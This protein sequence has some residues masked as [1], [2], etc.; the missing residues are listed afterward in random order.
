MITTSKNTHSPQAI[1]MQWIRH[2]T[3]RAAA[4]PVVEALESR[5]ML[6]APSNV[7]AF[8]TS[9]T[10]VTL[11]WTDNA[12][13]ETHF[14]VDRSVDGVN[15]KRI[16]SVPANS[17][18]FPDTGLQPGN[19]YHYR[20]KAIT[21]TV[22]SGW[23]TVSGS[24]LTTGTKVAPGAPAG[25]TA[26][27]PAPTLMT[28][29]WFDTADNE[30]HHLLERSLDGTN[31]KRIASMG[32]NVTE[33]LDSGL[34]PGV[35][36]HYRLRSVNGVAGSKWVR[37]SGTTVTEPLPAAPSDFVAVAGGMHQMTLTWVDNASNETHFL[38]DRSTDGVNFTR[39]ASLA[40]NSNTFTDTDLSSGTTYHYSLRA[41]HETGGS[42][43]VRTS[44]DTETPP[45]PPPQPD[46]LFTE[47]FSTGSDNFL[48]ISGT[49][50]V[51]GG[52]YQ[53]TS[54]SN[55]ATTH[56]NN[57]A[58]HTTT[59]EGDF[60]LAVDG[61]VPSS[62]GWADFAVIF[63]YQ[64]ANNY[65]FFSSNQSNDSLTSGIFKVVN[66][67]V[68]ELAEAAVISTDTT[69]RVRVVRSGSSISVYRDGTLVAMVEDETF[70]SGRIGFGTKGDNP[71]FDNLVVAGSEPA[72]PSEPPAAPSNLVAAAVSSSQIN[73]TWSDNSSDEASFRIERSDDGGNTWT[74]VATRAPDSTSWSASGLTAETT[75]HFRIRAYNV[76]GYSSYADVA[77]ATTQPAPQLGEKP[78]AHNTGPTNPDLLV[79]RGSISTTHDGQIIENVHVTGT[80][81]VRH[82]NVIIRNFK[83]SA[84]SSWGIRVYENGV[85]SVTIEDGDL[86]GSSAG[87]LVYGVNYTA[88]RLNVHHAGGDGF[89]AEG[90]VVIENCW[91]HDLGFS[92]GSHAD[93]IQ[94]QKGSNFIF[95]N[96]NIEV[97]INANNGGEDPN[98]AIFLGPAFGPI[99]NV[100]IEGNWMNGGNYTI[101]SNGCSNVV[102]RNNLFGRNYRYGTIS[103]HQHASSPVVWENNKWEDTGA[104][105]PR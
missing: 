73:L 58:V 55:A 79:A 101:Y 40:A 8:G 35:Q 49:W 13:N 59:L 93:G 9:D 65:Y 33:F 24:T 74:L 34:T 3:V 14:I 26:S 67:Q 27:S 28:V 45:P 84:T 22:N 60:D 54:A 82:K 42:K 68:S 48:V 29:S 97:Q 50:S 76:A 86:S 103:V 25:M 10:S 64:D 104:L 18:S 2:T 91:I 57:I 61:R 94:V 38:L 16:G 70:T 62:N 92:K 19:T 100:L 69:Y 51:V 95:R 88:R 96:N 83:L 17:T 5:T 72:P 102:I 75:Y 52:A 30:T 53:V 80:I 15:Y 11:T 99:D 90:N 44:A 32:A 7:G 6:F 39:I 20:V 31:F 12:S 98:A 46:A 1:A 47:D 105:I 81:E 77:S 66:G 78:G 87:A 36:Y 85:A 23:R 56:L 41:V 89:K 43:W 71:S 63:N 21:E 37:A 4:K